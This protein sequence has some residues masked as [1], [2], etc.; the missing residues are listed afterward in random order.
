MLVKEVGKVLKF[1][2]L[3]FILIIF[4]KFIDVGINRYCYE[5]LKITLFI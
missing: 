3:K 1:N 2:V 5:N 4:I